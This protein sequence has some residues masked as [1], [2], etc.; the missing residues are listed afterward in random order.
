MPSLYVGTYHKY[1]SGS[2]DGQWLDLEDYADSE[3]FYNACHKLHSDE[4]DPELMFQDYE[5]MPSFLYSECGNVDA[6]YTFID[7]DDHDREIIAIYD[8]EIAPDDFQSV[9]DRYAGSFDSLEDYAMDY[10]E[11]CMEIPTHL[12]AYIDYE[13]MG[14]DYT[15][16]MHVIE[17]DGRIH[18][19]DY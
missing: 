4:P 12:E 13:A 1:N 18:L 6:I 2:I 10:A 14:R 15:T 5:D 19:F 8:E 11:N 7:L 3:E 17:H 16:N 9:I